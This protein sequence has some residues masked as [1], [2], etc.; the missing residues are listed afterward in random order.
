MLFRSPFDPLATGNTNGPR[1]SRWSVHTVVGKDND[2]ATAYKVALARVGHRTQDSMEDGT[3]EGLMYARSEDDEHED[4]TQ[5]TTTLDSGKSSPIP[6]ITTSPKS[7]STLL[8]PSASPHI[9]FVR[10]Y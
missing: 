8:S 6:F 5:R 4:V 9:A 2:E 3:V 7:T 10:W 1:Y